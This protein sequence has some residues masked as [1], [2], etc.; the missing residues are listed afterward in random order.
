MLNAY[1]CGLKNTP[2][3]GEFEIYLIAMVD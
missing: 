2:S 1:T 3:T